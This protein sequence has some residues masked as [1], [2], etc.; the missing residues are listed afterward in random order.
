M[1]AGIALILTWTILRIPAGHAGVQH[2]ITVGCRGAALGIQQTGDTATASRQTESAVG[3]PV[4]I[5]V[6][7]ACLA[8]TTLL[9]AVDC[10]L[11]AVGL[12]R[13][14]LHTAQRIGFASEPRI[15]VLI[16]AALDTAMRRTI[17]A[18]ASRDRAIDVTDALH[19]LPT[20]R[21][22]MKSRQLALF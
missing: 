10:P 9:V 6:A 21:L 15:A 4:A 16:H 17:A 22:T 20:A 1:Q 19:A 7:R 13:A 3:R 8:Q 11:G 2:R 12:S 5:D 18:R 14:S